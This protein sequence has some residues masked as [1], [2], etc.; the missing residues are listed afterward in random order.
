MTLLVDQTEL[1]TPDGA[2]GEPGRKAAGALGLS[3]LALILIPTFVFAGADLFGGHLLLAGDNLIQSYPLRVLVGTDISHGVLPTW[4]PWIW[5]GTP[6]LAGLNAGAFY[7]T[8]FLFALVNPHA[9]WVIGEIFIFSSIG[10]GTCLLFHDSGTSPIASFLGAAVFTF[11]GAVLTQASVHTDMAEGLASL[12]WV[13]FAIRRIGVDG[14]WRWCV[15]L[16]VAFALT[17]VAGS[18]E[19]ML[20][21]AMLGLAYGLLRWSVQHGMW[22]RL[23]TRGAVAAG[24]SVGL[25]AAVWLPALHFIAVSQRANASESFASAFPFPPTGGLLGLIPYLEG[26]SA[27]FSQPAYFG[28]SNLGELGFYVGILPVIAVLSLL[29]PRWRGLLPA[30]E[31]RCWYGV[32]VVGLVLAIGAGTP[33]EHVLYHIPLYGSQRDSGRNIVDVDLAA[34]ALFAWWI[35]RGDRLSRAGRTAGQLVAFVPFGLVAV[36]G[37]LFAVSPSSLWTLLRAFPPLASADAT[38]W[39]AIGIA[40]GLSAL[41]G[42]IVWARA[43]LHRRRWLAIVAA[44]AFVDLALFASGSSY[45]SSQPVPASVTSDPVLKLVKAN[46]SP[47]G[48]YALVDPDLFSASQLV[49][50]GEP[51]LG[52]VSGLKSFSGYGAI[53]D[54]TYSLKTRTHE[55]VSLNEFAL[56]E[57]E[58]DSLGA[59]VIVTVPEEFLVPIGGLPGKDGALVQ[60]AE[61]PG[62]DPVLPGGNVPLPQLGVEQ[63]S[64]ARPAPAISRTA[65]FRWFFGTELRPTAA[66]LVLASPAR[67]QL[68]RAGVVQPDGS[69]RWHSPVRLGRGTLAPRLA[70]PGVRAVGVVVELLRGSVLGPAQ[71]AIE[72]GGRAYLVAGALARAVTP[73][74]WRDVGSADGFAVFRSDFQPISAWVQSAEIPLIAHGTRIEVTSTTPSASGEILALSLEYGTARVESTSPNAATVTVTTPKAG[75]LAWSTAWDPGWRAE[76]TPEHGRPRTVATQRVGFVLGVPVPKGTSV[77]RFTYVPLRWAEGVTISLGSL[78]GLVAVSGGLL[79]VGRL[80]RRRR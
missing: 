48:R 78:I 39:P 70:L 63:L 58:F 77:V 50:A 22:K 5:S 45:A 12:P 67:G 20:D 46:L 15:L 80:R 41:A 40:A 36:T 29:T 75:L 25:S 3:I 57:G 13:L 10:V 69:V 76:L 68:V 28:R 72:T 71:I 16:G 4:D 18:P 6:L 42:G 8:T 26:G 62:T 33:L 21:T 47:A 14:R 31:R 17:I 74:T 61:G 24:L 9:A 37:A 79:I 60:L 53:V 73:K 54:S 64:L 38:I 51:D 2:G 35:D 59:Q 52:I 49:P 32:L 65:H 7:P 44:F 27:M 66:E 1:E 56:Q 11:G 19:A 30:G 55:R 34:S 43:H 23:V